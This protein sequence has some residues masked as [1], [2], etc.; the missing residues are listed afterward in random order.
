MEPDLGQENHPGEILGLD[1][2]EIEEEVVADELGFEIVQ[3]EL[4]RD[5]R[6][7]EAGRLCF[8]GVVVGVQRP[9]L[10]LVY[11]GHRD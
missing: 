7:T 10:D 3:M 2:S 11:I 9:V 8:S 1:V 4:E 6:E 5:G